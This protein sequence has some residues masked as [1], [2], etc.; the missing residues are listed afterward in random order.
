MRWTFAGS[1]G[2]LLGTLAASQ[3]GC[4]I[5]KACGAGAA[6][7][8]CALPPGTTRVTRQGIVVDKIAFSSWAYS[9][10]AWRTGM[11]MVDAFLSAYN[12]AGLQRRPVFWSPGKN[13]YA[14]TFG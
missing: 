14:Q 1:L 9:G 10:G 5:Y 6:T 3:L 13:Q 11:A 2:V 7:G 12:P 8:E 4:E